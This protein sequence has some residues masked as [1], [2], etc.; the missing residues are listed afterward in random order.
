METAKGLSEQGESLRSNNPQAAALV[1]RA[2]RDRASSIATDEQA[3]TAAERGLALGV[4]L[5]GGEIPEFEDFALLTNLY[6]LRDP[7]TLTTTFSAAELSLY[8][9]M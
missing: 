1:V 3:Y 6:R 5:A 4:Q 2:A 7:G 9:L 8:L